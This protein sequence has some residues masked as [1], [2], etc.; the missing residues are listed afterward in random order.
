MRERPVFSGAFLFFWGMPV[1]RG[2]GIG[3]TESRETVAI[4]IKAGR[5]RVSRFPPPSL[6]REG[7]TQWETMSYTEDERQVIRMREAG[8]NARFRFPRY[9]RTVCRIPAGVPE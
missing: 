8:I 9:S 5:F 1:K 3:C 6:Q 2:G 7:M 4:S